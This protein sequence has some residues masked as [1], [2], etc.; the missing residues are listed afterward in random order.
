M[1]AAKSPMFAT[2][3]GLVL[4]GFKA[5]D[6]RQARYSEAPSFKGDGKKKMKA[7]NKFFSNILEKT[8]GLLIDDFDD[9][10]N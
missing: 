10:I 2:T 3:V 6:I 4:S 1:D 9:K 8:K 7:G 5:L